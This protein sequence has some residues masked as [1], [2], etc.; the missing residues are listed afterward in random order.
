MI[1]TG[2]SIT[3]IHDERSKF[4]TLSVGWRSGRETTKQALQE[5]QEAASAVVSQLTPVWQGWS[6]DPESIRFSAIIE[7]SMVGQ[8]ARAFEAEIRS[9]TR[10]ALGKPAIALVSPKYVDGALETTL[11][12]SFDGCRTVEATP[13]KSSLKQTASQGFEQ[14]LV[15]GIDPSGVTSP[16]ATF[17]AMCLLVGTPLSLLYAALNDSKT[18]AILQLG[19]ELENGN[20]TISWNIV[21]PQKNSLAASMSLV[22]A[23]QGFS[24]EQNRTAVSQAR[25]FAIANLSRAW[26]APLEL[27]NSIVQYET[28]GWSGNLIRSPREKLIEVDDSALEAALNEFVRPLEEVLGKCKS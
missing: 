27:A 28:M 5:L 11:L 6:A 14:V 8:W 26:R 9:R 13:A 7:P 21:A 15:H 4:S 18:G 3:V 12:E 22:E 19:R 1:D 17:M 25:E 2:H 16:A 10:N 20:P 23:V 24:A